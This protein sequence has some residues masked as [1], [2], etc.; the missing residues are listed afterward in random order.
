MLQMV[1]HKIDSARKTLATLREKGYKTGNMHCLAHEEY[2][3]FTYNQS[4]FKIERHGSTDL[5]WLSKIGYVEI[6]LHREPKNIKQIT[7]CRQNGRWYAVIACGICKPILK[8]I[9]RRQ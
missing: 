5:L 3:S 7:T 6:R 2:N 8:F 1:V 9:L 4:G